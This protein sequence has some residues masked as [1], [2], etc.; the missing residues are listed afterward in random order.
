M[1]KIS[2]LGSF[3][4]LA[5]IEK[6]RSSSKVLLVTGQNSFEMSGAAR[7]IER[8]RLK[9]S[10]FQF[11]DFEVNP[12]LQD[13]IAGARNAKNNNVDL[14]VGIGGGSVLDMAKLIR[15]TMAEPEAAEEIVLGNKPVCPVGPAIIQVPTTAGSGSEATH[16]AVAYINDQKYSVA[17]RHLYADSVILDGTFVGSASKYQRAC[18]VLDATA[19]AIESYWSLGAS[20]IS[21]TF[22][23][24]ALEKLARIQ[25]DF[26][27]SGEK[28]FLNQ[29][30]LEAASLAGSAINIS[31]TT[32]PHAWSY[33][34]TTRHG[35]PHGHAV[36]ATLPRV[37]EVHSKAATQRDLSAQRQLKHKMA[38]LGELF[39]LTD[40]QSL[41]S[42]LRAYMERLQIPSTW[43]DL[44]I[45]Y[46]ERQLIAQSANQ[47]RMKNNPIAF[48]EEEIS[49]IFDI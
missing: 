18:N 30:A 20:S 9:Q 7:S 32:A 39:G 47:A 24:S 41:A 28:L 26:V 31:K 27:T 3:A 48:D 36:W 12:K 25:T 29:A 37:F 16:F 42:Q 46:A 8:L 23:I 5:D 14:I 13:V 38:R 17:S 34:I 4:K 40:R 21:D 35:I 2:G 1:Q 45:N 43:T 15:A 33:R 22:A 11:S 44:G 49:W 10:V 19:Q 6:F